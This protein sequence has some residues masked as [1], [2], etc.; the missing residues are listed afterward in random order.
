MNVRLHALLFGLLAMATLLAGCGGNDPGITTAVKAKFAADDTVKAYQIDVDTKDNVVTLTGTVDNPEA[1]TVAVSMARN[2]DRV[3]D[4]IDNLTVGANSEASAADR[5]EN[6]VG[7]AGITTEVKT[8][9]LADSTVS[10]LKID[11]DTEDGVVMLSGT[12]KTQAEKDQAVL[13][14]R[15]VGGVKDV[16]DHLTIETRQ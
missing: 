3:R 8:K 16:M 5:V 2:T 12:V 15:Q 9:L 13:L 1:K 14:A 4:V 7:D 6:A 11:V 10:G